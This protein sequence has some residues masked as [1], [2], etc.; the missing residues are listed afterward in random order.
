[1]ELICDCWL[2][3]VRSGDGGVHQSMWKM[4]ADFPLR[5]ET[6]EKSTALKDL[7]IVPDMVLRI[8]Y[9]FGSSSTHFEVICSSKG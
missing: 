3:Y 9:D 5:N 4:M 1:M 7:E 8:E 2:D 6:P